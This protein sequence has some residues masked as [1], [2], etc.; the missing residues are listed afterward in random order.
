MNLVF[1]GAEAIGDNIGTVQ[2]TTGV[3][4]VDEDYIQTAMLRE[5]VVPG[6]YVYLEVH[7][8]G[9]GMDDATLPRIF[10]PF[11]TTK[12]TGRGLGL[13][14]AIGIVRGHGGDPRL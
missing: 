1:N 9:C 5:G 4:Q 8:T 7:D 11:F 14:A 2:V 6:R 3:Q 13:A 12:F 10:D